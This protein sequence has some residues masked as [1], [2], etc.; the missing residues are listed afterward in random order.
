MKYNNSTSNYL[1]IHI[2]LSILYQI[3]AWKPTTGSCCPNFKCL[4]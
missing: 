3:I 1:M 2:I 4:I